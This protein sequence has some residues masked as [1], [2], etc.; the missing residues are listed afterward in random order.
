MQL[1]PVIQ[2]VGSKTR[3]A[4]NITPLFAKIA[5]A[6]YVE[7]FG[8]SGAMFCAKAP[9]DFEVYNDLNGVLVN[10]FKALR[11]MDAQKRFEELAAVTPHSRAIWYEFRDILRERH[12]GDI[13][14]SDELLNKAGFDGYDKEVVLAFMIFYCQRLGFGGNYLNSFAGGLNQHSCRAY[15][16]A[17]DRIGD[18]TRR[19]QNVLIENMDAFDCVAKYDDERTLFYLDPPYDCKKSDGYLSGWTIADS[20]RLVE[21]LTNARASC[22]L[23]CYDSE[24][25][26]T[27]LGAGYK[28]RQFE[29]FSSVCKTSKGAK[30]KRIETVYYRLSHYAKAERRAFKARNYLFQ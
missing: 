30:F 14:K 22:V 4:A 27:L 20:T 29:A 23:S 11:R 9:E 7:P 5:R 16:N 10:L 15:R 24:L 6:S 18:Y 3:M 26:E 2:W 21:T 1:N 13:T 12:D 19:F 28:K 25:Y 8:G 17:V